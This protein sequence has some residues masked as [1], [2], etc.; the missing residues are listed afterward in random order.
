VRPL[1]GSLSTNTKLSRGLYGT[2]VWDD[3]NVIDVE[4]GEEPSESL[5][6]DKE[7]VS[8]QPEISD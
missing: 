8:G 1:L 2:I 6:E 4:L 7:I 5:T 3:G